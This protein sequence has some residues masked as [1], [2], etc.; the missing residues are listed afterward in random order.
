[1][2]TVGVL[3]AYRWWE[4]SGD[5]ISV[6]NMLRAIAA[7]L[8][9][10]VGVN[11][12]WDSRLLEVTPAL[13]AGGWRTVD[14]FAVSPVIDRIAAE[15]WPTSDCQD[16]RFD[17][18]YFFREVPATLDLRAFCN[19]CGM[20]LENARDLA[21]PAGV[22]LDDQLRR[23]APELVIGEGTRGVFVITQSEALGRILDSSA[24]SQ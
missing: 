18:W 12:S 3:G 15:H 24:V 19:W 23:Y 22:D 10:L 17:E 6:G 5:D 14:G 9:G 1:M 20:S 2:K 4:I 13:A 16:G 7:H 8:V 21:F 11:V